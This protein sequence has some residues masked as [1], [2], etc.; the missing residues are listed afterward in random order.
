MGVTKPV[1]RIAHRMICG[2]AEESSDDE[3]P[4]EEWLRIPFYTPS[5][6]EPIPCIYKPVD[7]PKGLVALCGGMMACT[8]TYREMIEDLNAEG[9][10]VISMSLPFP[11]NFERTE[12]GFY[13]YYQEMVKSFYADP[14]SPVHQIARKENIPVH[15]FTHSTGGLVYTDLMQNDPEFEEFVTRSIRNAAHLAPFFSAARACPG[16]IFTPAQIEPKHDSLTRRIFLRHATANPNDRL[17]DHLRELVFPLMNMVKG[18]VTGEKMSTATKAIPRYKDILTLMKHGESLLLQAKEKLEKTEHPMI[19]ISGR[20]D[21]KACHSFAGRV[22]DA[23]GAHIEHIDSRHNPWVRNG[24]FIRTLMQGLEL[25][26]RTG[27]SMSLVSALTRGASLRTTPHVVKTPTQQHAHI[28]A[29]GYG[30]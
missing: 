22:A 12:E 9:Y 15:A 25:Q 10:S 19:F 1:A 2:K 5:I 29:R 16:E 17:G 11:E 13:P 3:L 30:T 14:N 4:P 6:P 21:N 27:G 23:M 24:I 8:A 20:G 18:W 7:N 26:G 28:P